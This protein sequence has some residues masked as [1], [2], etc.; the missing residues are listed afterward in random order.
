MIS[1]ALLPD[2]HASGWSAASRGEAR[3]NLLAVPSTDKG[4]DMRRVSIFAAVAA[5]LAITAAQ[6]A[7]LPEQIKQAGTVRLTVSST[8]APMEYRDPATN[9]LIGLDIDLVSEIAKRLSLKIVWSETAFAEIV[10]ALQT[11]RA[12]FVISGI[13]DR[14]SRRETADFV[15][16]L[17]T[18]PQFFVLAPNATQ[19]AVDLCGKKVGTTRSSIFPVE[20]EKWSKANCEAAGKPA[21]Q[22]VP[23]ENAIDV[24]SQLKQGRI[25]AAVQGSETLPYALKQEPGKYR[26]VGEPFSSGYQGIM[27][28]K[29]EP[30][31]R[32]VVMDVLA[33]MIADGAYQ[34]ILAKWDLAANAVTE[35]ML[36][37]AAQ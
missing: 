21:V 34:T 19:A 32:Q 8:Y 16:Y 9:E 37:A 13:S 17:K 6:A 4:A 36:N 20:I 12:D 18:G 28:R 26:I 27:F 5:L 10:P 14:L 29:D 31:L 24:R 35:P 2:A 3:G 7:E 11:K 25:D 1:S 30:A 23:G 33:T 15:D 22:F